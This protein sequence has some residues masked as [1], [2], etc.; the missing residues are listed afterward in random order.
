[1]LKSEADASTKLKFVPP[2]EE[3]GKLPRYG[4]Y[5]VSNGLKVHGRLADAKNSWRNRGWAWKE[6]GELEERYGK[7][8][9]GRAY[10][11]LHA[12]ILENVD[13]EW[14][15]LYEIA[16]GLKEAQLP[17]MKEYYRD[18]KYSWDRWSLVD[19][20]FEEGY[21]KK[22]REE[23]PDRFIFTHKATPMTTDEYVAWRLSVEHERLG[24]K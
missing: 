20:T 18:S 21:Y 23:Q 6:T 16:P 17:W 13:G 11:T 7:I 15:T 12:F 22:L 9:P 4:S 19:N 3:A 24:I 14:F 8:V 10:V 2:K 1:M 5:V